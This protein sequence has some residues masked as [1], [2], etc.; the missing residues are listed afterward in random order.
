MYIRM[1]LQG[2]M[3]TRSSVLKATPASVSILLFMMRVAMNMRVSI[4]VMCIDIDI[5]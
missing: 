5:L 2:I 4:N 3:I 1:G